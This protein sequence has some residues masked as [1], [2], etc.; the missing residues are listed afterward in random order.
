MNKNE[1]QFYQNNVAHVNEK[2]GQMRAIALQS[3]SPLIV[4]GLQTGP[5]WLLL[6]CSH[7]KVLQEKRF[8]QLKKCL[9]KMNHISKAKTN[10]SMKKW[11]LFHNQVL[12]SR[13]S[14]WIR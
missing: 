4:F 13:K 9:K 10:N 2:Y 3:I 14:I 6:V 12:F 7:Q 1:V 8:R 5:Q 11:I